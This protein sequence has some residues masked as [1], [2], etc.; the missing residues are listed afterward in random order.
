MKPKL[1]PK[2]K[3]KLRSNLPIFITVF[4]LIAIVAVCVFASK[5]TDNAPSDN[6]DTSSINWESYTEKTIELENSLKITSPGIYV[7][8]G[9][10]S[11]GMIEISTSGIVK[12]VLAGV[13]IKNSS[14]PAILV[15]EAKTVFIETKEGTINTL[16][17]SE[18]YSGFNEDICATIFSKDNLV[19]EGSGTLVVYGNH[20]DGIVSKDKLKITSGTYKLETKDEGIRGRDSVYISGGNIEIDSG[21]DAIKSN[22]SEEIGKGTI[23]IDGGE[24]TISAG[25]DGIH[26]EK[27]VTINDGIINIKQ[28]YEGI[29]GSSIAINGGDIKVVASDDGLNAAGG[30]DGSS[31]NMRDYQDSSSNYQI[32]VNDGKIHIYSS[33]DGIDSNGSFTM[34]GGEVIVDGP[35]SDGNGALDAETG[36][37]YN[38]GTLIAVGSA[39]MAVSPN[40]SSNGYSISVFF[41]S[42]FSAGTK[43]S[44]KDAYE[45]TILSYVPTKT[46]AHASFSSPEFQEGSTY[47]IYVNDVEYASVKL[48]G[49]TT[50]SGSGA[51]RM[52]GPRFGPGR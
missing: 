35:I 32:I 16:T 2:P 10:L 44:I 42:S 31:P 40:N 13:T 50:R 45:N 48:S 47:T 4:L 25:D 6:I 26:A 37:V 39:G 20:E 49:K 3:S 1:S 17:D 22:N 9:N 51:Q 18:P 36:V 43:I 15:S 52:F 23:L 38:G 21:G 29:E 28:S 27:T 11:D 24:L 19:L 46:F 8:T 12:L 41:D 33:G 5:K 14:G 7:L 34:N 30:N